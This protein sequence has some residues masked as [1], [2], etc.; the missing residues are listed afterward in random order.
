MLLTNSNGLFIEKLRL[1]VLPLFPIE[2]CQPGERSGFVR[3][4]RS[5]RLFINIQCALVQSFA[6][7]LGWG[8]SLS[9]TVSGDFASCLIGFQ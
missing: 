5:Q 3:M 6:R 8:T 1:L 4:L 2:G 9:A 7:L